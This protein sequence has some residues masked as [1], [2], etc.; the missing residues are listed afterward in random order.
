MRLFRAFTG[1]SPTMGHGSAVFLAILLAGGLVA[2]AACGSSSATSTLAPAALPKCSVTASAAPSTVPPQGGTGRVTVSTARECAWSA[3][4]DAVWLSIRSGATGQGEGTVE[5]AAAANPDPIVRRGA[6]VLNAQ[7]VE[8]VQTAA[9]CSFSTSVEHISIGAEG[10]AARVD[11]SASSGLCT[12]T[13]SSPVSWI[14]IRAGGSGSGNGAVELF[15]EPVGPTARSAD[16]L[17]AGRA[18]RVS[19]EAQGTP[20]PT[21]TP[22]PTPA[23]SPNPTP[24]PSP[25]PEPDPTPTPS[26]TPTPTPSPS[27]TPDPP[28]PACTIALEPDSVVVNHQEYS[29]RIR[30]IAGDGCAWTAS[31]DAS[32]ISIT[33]GASGTGT[34]EISYAIE[35]MPGGQNERI[36]TITVG[37]QTFTV[38]QQR[39]SAGE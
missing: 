13:A 14:A 19:Q 22:T 5:Y 38:R 27:P 6:I 33:A 21:P 1:V 25:S 36:G 2:T 17:V 20:A 10:G 3:E 11:V 12:W 8:I 7:R 9:A 18:V 4:P 15:I 26:P 16:V 37:D 39:G 30:V 32:W 31:S 34:G 29:G 28:P 24:T 23:P 35:R